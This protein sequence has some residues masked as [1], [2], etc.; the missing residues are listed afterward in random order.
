MKISTYVTI[1]LVIGAVLFIFGMMSQE[2]TQNYPDSN[3]NNSEWVDKYNYASDI[4]KTITPMSTALN[5]IQ[6]ENVGWFTRLTSGIVAMP[7]AVITIPAVLF[8]S[9]EFGGEILTGLFNGLNIPPAILLIVIILVLWWGISKLVELYQ[10]W[11][12]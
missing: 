5:N 2:A 6:D 1:I 8:K 3:L 11:Q 4:N 9:F 7:L 10:R 12:L